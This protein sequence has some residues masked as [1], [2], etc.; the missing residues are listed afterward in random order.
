MIAAA[1]ESRQPIRLSPTVGFVLPLDGSSAAAAIAARSP[2]QEPDRD[3]D[4]DGAQVPVRH[5]HRRR[6]AVRTRGWATNDGDVTEGVRAVSSAILDTDDNPV[7]ALAVCGPSTRIGTDDL[8]R[9]GAMVAEAAA[10]VFRKR[11]ETPR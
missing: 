3:A 5:R 10:E 4:A 6:R 7:G 2:S 11:R 1:V 8:P 9:L